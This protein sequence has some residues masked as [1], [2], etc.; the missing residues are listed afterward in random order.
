MSQ[1]LLSWM[2]PWAPAVPRWV[3]LSP[4]VSIP[5]VVDE[6][7]GAVLPMF[8]VLVLTLSQSLLSWMSPWAPPC[9][10]RT[11]A[12]TNASQSLLSW[13]SPWAAVQGMASGAV[14]SV[15]IP[16]VVDEPLGGVRM[17]V[18]FVEHD[19]LNPCC[20]G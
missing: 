1:S 4:D 20:R 5:V 2:S 14:N 17:T 9:A 13:M 7:L 3:P 15:S 6:P 19:G 12:R 18:R 8:T 16:V 11:D 10:A